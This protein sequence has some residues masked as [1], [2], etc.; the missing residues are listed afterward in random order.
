M[1]LLISLIPDVVS[2]FKLDAFFFFQAEIA[3][4]LSKIRSDSRDPDCPMGELNVYVRNLREMLKLKE[5]Y[6]LSMS[7]NTFVASFFFHHC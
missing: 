3:C 2:R 6:Q 5:V 1:Y 7:Y 4:M